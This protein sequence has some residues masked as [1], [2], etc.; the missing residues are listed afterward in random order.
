MERE[1]T[2][3]PITVRLDDEGGLDEI[4]LRDAAGD[5]LFHLERM[6]DDCFWLRCYPT[7]ALPGDKE[8]GAML[9]ARRGEIATQFG[10]ERA[11]QAGGGT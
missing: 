9:I 5:C 6:A 4:V 2:H 11:T 8:F 10:W 3:G 7:P 1:T